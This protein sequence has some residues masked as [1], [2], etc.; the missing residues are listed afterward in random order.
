MDIAA[1]Y[2]VDENGEK[3]FAIVPMDKW[4]EI[5]KLIRKYEVLEEIKNGYREVK[6][7]LKM[8]QNFLH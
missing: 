1:N 6:N 5:Q 3:K 2:I 4:V 8:A 7:Q